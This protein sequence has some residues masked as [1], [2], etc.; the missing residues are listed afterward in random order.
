MHRRPGPKRG[1]SARVHTLPIQ[2]FQSVKNAHFSKLWQLCYLSVYQGK[3]RLVFWPLCCYAL[4]GTQD[5]YEVIAFI[6]Q[7]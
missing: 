3:S 1:W 7:K 6:R 2:S 5:C 4:G